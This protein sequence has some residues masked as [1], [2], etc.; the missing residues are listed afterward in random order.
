MIVPNARRDT[1][2]KEMKSLMKTHPELRIRTV[3]LSHSRSGNTYS[4]LS[5]QQLPNKEHSA[6][7]DML[8]SE[9]I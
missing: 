9:V 5:Y 4:L 1:I 3:N 2:V 6:P 7:L 8:T